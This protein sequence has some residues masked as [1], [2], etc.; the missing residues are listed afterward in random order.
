M[1]RAIRIKA[2]RKQK[3]MAYTYLF[4]PFGA[5][6]NS[7]QISTPQI[8]ATSGDALLKAYATALLTSLCLR[9]HEADDHTTHPDETTQHTNQMGTGITIL[10]IVCHR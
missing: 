9:S 6:L 7:F 8:M 5:A 3:N 10:E 2:A 1:D 4:V